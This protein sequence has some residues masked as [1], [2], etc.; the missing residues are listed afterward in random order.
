M[1]PAT[2]K[3]VV[4]AYSGG[5]DTSIILKWLKSSPNL[6]SCIGGWKISRKLNL[7]WSGAWVFMRNTWGTNTRI[8]KARS[9]IWPSCTGFKAGTG[10]HAGSENY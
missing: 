5:L 1:N 7:Y 9:I 10:L 8:W 2:K 6:R 4:L 3:K